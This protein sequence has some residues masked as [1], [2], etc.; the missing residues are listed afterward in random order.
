MAAW[1]PILRGKCTATELKTI[2][3]LDDLAD[4]NEVLDLEDAINA[5]PPKS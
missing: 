2:L 5:L 3:T 1:R 4:L